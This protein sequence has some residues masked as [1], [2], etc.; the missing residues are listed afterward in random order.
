MTSRYVLQ[1]SN[2]RQ[3]LS[4]PLRNSPTRYRALVESFGVK[5]VGM[6]RIKLK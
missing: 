3:W 1:S 4:A 2:G 6:L 5:V